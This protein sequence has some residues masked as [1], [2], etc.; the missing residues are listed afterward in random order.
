MRTL[1]QYLIF[2]GLLALCGCPGSIIQPLPQG[3]GPGTYIGEF[4]GEDANGDFAPIGII[5]ITIGSAGQ[6][7]ATGQVEGR[8]IS[9]SGLLDPDGLLDGDI[10]DTL[11]EL[12]GR[13]SGQLAG[14]QLSGSF[15]LPRADEDDLTGVWDAQL[16]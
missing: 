4:Q 16:Q 8:S 5:T 12:S 6:V 2:A 3:G 7:S 14:S 1:L 10:T 9:V 13:F 11:S 15:R